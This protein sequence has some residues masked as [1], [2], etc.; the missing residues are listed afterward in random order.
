MLRVE[1]RLAN[2]AEDEQRVSMMGTKISNLLHSIVMLVKLAE[3]NRDIP[4]SFEPDATG[5]RW[6]FVIS[7]VK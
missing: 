4:K 3:K 5:H 7:Q 2:K 1:Y 6:V